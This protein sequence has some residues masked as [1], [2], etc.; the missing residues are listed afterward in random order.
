MVL[1]REQD[2]L[3]LC[4]DDGAGGG[5]DAADSHHGKSANFSLE[6][7]SPSAQKSAIRSLE[8]L[9]MLGGFLL[10]RYGNT[11]SSTVPTLLL[12]Q[13]RISFHFYG[14]LP[15]CLTE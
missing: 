10:L 8:F 7:L 12:N 13:Y 11:A 14:T 4:P 5:D 1:Y 3:E 9:K 6:N 15:T 2:P